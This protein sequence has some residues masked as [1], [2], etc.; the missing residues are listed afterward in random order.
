MGKLPLG[1]SFYIK[2]SLSLTSLEGKHLIGCGDKQQLG[3]PLMFCPWLGA[4]KVS[5]FISL[6]S[7]EQGSR[8]THAAVIHQYPCS[9][10]QSVACL[11]GLSYA[12]SKYFW[13]TMGSIGDRWRD[14]LAIINHDNSLKE[15]ND[16]IT[17]RRLPPCALWKCIKLRKLTTF[18][19]I[20]QLMSNITVYL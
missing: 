7:A 19:L 18:L 14:S 1:L 10:I 12:N 2:N 17:Y 9:C 15:Q 20:C 16:Y 5:F 4:S 11:A 3:P 6:E 8:S 13:T